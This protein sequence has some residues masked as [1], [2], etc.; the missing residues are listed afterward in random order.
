M[1]P[2]AQESHDGILLFYSHQKIDFEQLSKV[3]QMVN[4][5]LIVARIQ[6]RQKKL[7]SS[8]MAHDRALLTRPVAAG[9]PLRLLSDRFGFVWFRRQNFQL[10]ITIW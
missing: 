5:R 4:L 3:W 2:F 10:C 8:L 9:R 6:L 7:L 1:L